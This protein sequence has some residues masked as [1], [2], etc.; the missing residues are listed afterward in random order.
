[1]TETETVSIAAVASI[2]VA[3]AV[4]KAGPAGLLPWMLCGWLAHVGA[5]CTCRRRTAAATVYTLARVQHNSQSLTS[6]SPAIAAWAHLEVGCL[7][8]NPN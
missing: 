6:S 7:Y 1:M 2:A 5:A 3:F 8:R 4:R